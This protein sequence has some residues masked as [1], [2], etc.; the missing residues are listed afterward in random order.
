VHGGTFLKE[1]AMGSVLVTCLAANQLFEADHAGQAVAAYGLI[2]I[3][4]MLYTL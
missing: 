3:E 2:R 1:K 4:V